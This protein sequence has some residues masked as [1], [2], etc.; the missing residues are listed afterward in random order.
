M[1]GQFCPLGKIYRVNDCGSV[2]GFIYRGD[3]LSSGNA[4]HG[5]GD[6]DCRSARGQAFSG[7]FGSVNYGINAGITA[8][9]EYPPAQLDK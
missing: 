3:L 1:G 8:R 9:G 7:I 6:F 4:H 5:D 2:S